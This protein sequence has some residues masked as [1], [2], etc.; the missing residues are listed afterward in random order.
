MSKHG[1]E[2]SHRAWH[3]K[4]HTWECLPTRDRFQ[5]WCC[6]STA[7]EGRRLCR[8]RGSLSKEEEEEPEETRL[9]TPVR[10]DD[11]TAAS[12]VWRFILVRKGSGFYSRSGEADPHYLRRRFHRLNFN[13]LL[14]GVGLCS[15]VFFWEAVKSFVFFVFCFQ[16]QQQRKIPPFSKSLYV[17]KVSF[18]LAKAASFIMCV[19]LSHCDVF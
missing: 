13:R 9:R 18:R 7:F 15:V 1:V 16:Q 6:G 4:R 10:W 12:E 8:S 5:P 17:F 2:T 19:L 3:L 14:L 11:S